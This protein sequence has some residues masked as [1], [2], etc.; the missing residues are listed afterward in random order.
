MLYNGVWEK[1]N[2]DRAAVFPGGWGRG[3]GGERLNLGQMVGAEDGAG[4]CRQRGQA[5]PILAEVSGQDAL[6]RR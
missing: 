2:K 1:S 3:Q 6:S 4:S 5:K